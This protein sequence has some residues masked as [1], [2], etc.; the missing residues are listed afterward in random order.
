MCHKWQNY[1]PEERGAMIC[2][3][4]DLQSTLGS[5][6]GY[7]YPI[8]CCNRKPLK[9]EIIMKTLLAN[10]KITV[11]ILTMALLIY[12]LQGIS[13]GQGEA[14]TFTPGETNTSL[15]V[16]FKDS[17]WEFGQYVYQVQL[18]RKS[19]QG[20]WITKC[21]VVWDNP[22]G[23][24]AGLY[25]M[26]VIFT[27]LEPGTTYEAR[28]RDTNLRQCHDN[29]PA[30]DSWSAITEGTTHLVTPPRVEFADANLATAVRKAL[31]LDTNGD[32]IELL[33]IP[34]A[35]LGKLTTLYLEEN[36]ISDLTPLAQFTQLTTLFLVGNNISDITPLAQLTKLTA[37]DLSNNNISDLT[38]LAQLTQLTKLNLGGFNGNNISDLTPLTQLTLLTELDLSENNIS[39]VT[40]L[41][42]L[43]LLTELDLSH[44]N[45]R[46][47]TP[48]A[49]LTQLTWLYLWFNNIS[50]VTPLAQLINLVYLFLSYNDI[51]DF[52]PLAQLSQRTS[53]DAD[54]PFKGVFHPSDIELMT[55]STPQ[56]LTETTLN[57]GSVT[58]TLL[59]SGAAYDTSIDNIRNALTLTGIDGVTVSDV[60][61]VSDTELKVT[62]GF[63]GNLENTTTLTISLGAEAVSGYEGRALTGAIPVYPE[64]GLTVSSSYPLS[65]VTLNGSVVTLTLSSGA[66][67]PLRR[68][69]SGALTISGI[70][71]Y[72]RDVHYVS[73]TVVTIELTFKGSIDKDTVL[74]FTLGAD[75]IRDYEGPALTAEIPV[76]ASTEV[77]LTGELVASTAFPLTKETLDGSVV[78]LTLKNHSYEESYE[79]SEDY[80]E[81]TIVVSGIP[82]VNIAEFRPYT[83][84]Y[85]LSSTEISVE[86]SFSGNLENDATLTFIVPPRVI[87]DYSGPPLAAALPVTVKTG[88]QVLVPASQRP[89]MFWI[90]TDTDKIE[91]LEPFDAVTQEVTS[92]TVDAAGGK[93]YWAEQGSSGGTIKRANLDGTNVEVLTTEPIT[94][95][96][97]VVDTADNK[98]YWTDSTQG[99]IHSADLNGENITTIIELDDIKDI[100]VDTEGGKLYFSDTFAIRRANLDGTNVE[101]ILTGWGTRSTTGIGGIAVADGKI[102]WTE[103]LGWSHEGNI[104]RAN[105]NG[106]NIE[107]LAT[108][109]GR[110]TSIAVDTVGGKVYCANSSGGIQR[111]DINGGEIEN[112]VYG[113]AAPGDFALGAVSMQPTTPT[114]P[115]IPISAATLKF[116]PSPV[117]SPAVGEQLTLSINIADGE[118]VA[119]YQGTVQFDGTALRYVSSAMVI[120]SRQVRSRCLSTRRGTR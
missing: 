33:K 20:D 50:D 88:Q 36:N 101:I 8:A 52:T 47:V 37:L 25:V 41:A 120:T 46:D 77:E 54:E 68:S 70:T 27:D 43:T 29:P 44:N 4:I 100:A 117:Q 87:K 59:P 58:L 53:I 7:I 40:P 18:R 96:S 28:Y 45:I 57:G 9:K 103:L 3:T 55:V 119:A 6:H 19:P 60:I 65:A 97:L 51:S 81:P 12:G 107:T 49:Q 86:L 76:S 16:S 85:F 26:T 10:R 73:H 75:A 34:E 5:V 112:V 24:K 78:K 71:F 61:R 116:L 111:M 94:A 110:P 11:S 21:K 98:L 1:S 67:E 39:D 115:E 23:R 80:S 106:T 99:R 89:S 22:Y 32:H 79:D 102:Y 42:Q 15:I 2:I 62:F 92:L 93:I 108:P 64:L 109:L 48:L 95:S 17:L 56:P 113:I 35:E 105:L 83:Y 91:S 118:N 104:H 69:I 74:T 31:D 13:Y 82:N 63:T 72:T 90:N 30:P 38:P 14:P 66:F 84:F 114:P